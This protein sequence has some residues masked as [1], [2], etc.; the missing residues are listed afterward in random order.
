MEWPLTSSWMGTTAAVKR[1]VRPTDS[2]RETRVGRDT[3]TGIVPATVIRLAEFPVVVFPKGPTRL[4]LP[5]A[6]I[7]I[8]KGSH[9]GAQAVSAISAQGPALQEGPL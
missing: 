8:E 7:G 9:L 5:F 2:D 3:V 4:I 6:D 1:P